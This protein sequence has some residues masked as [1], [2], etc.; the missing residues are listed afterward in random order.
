MYIYVLCIC[1]CA[2]I[3]VYVYIYIC[4][5]VCLCVKNSPAVVMIDSVVLEGVALD[6]VFL[7]LVAQSHTRAKLRIV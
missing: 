2:F 7:L 5:C 3:R 1:M 4:I 6:R